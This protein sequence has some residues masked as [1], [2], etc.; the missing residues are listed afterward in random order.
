MKKFLFIILISLVAVPAFAADVGVSISVGE[1]G[2]YGRIDIGSAPRPVVI[3]PKPVVIRP[4]PTHVIEEPLYLRV[5]PGHA[6]KWK[7][8]CAKYNACDRPVYFVKDK[9]Y[10]D[11]YRPHYRA[12]Q[13]EYGRGE[14]GSRHGRDHGD[15]QD[16]DRDDKREHGKGHYKD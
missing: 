2:F 7:K 8:H 15:R 9:W 12:H 10:N 16:R 4:A 3:Y 1:P 6:K 11:V 5:P 13:E 14:H